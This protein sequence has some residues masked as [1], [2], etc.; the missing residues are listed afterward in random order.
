MLFHL[1]AN[2]QKTISMTAYDPGTA[3]GSAVARA[4]SLVFVKDG[5]VMP[6]FI[7]APVWL[8]G[9]KLWWPLAA[10]VASIGAIVGIVY[11][12]D[13]P[14]VIAV[15]GLIAVHLV[16]AFEAGDLQRAGLEG[17][18]YVTLGTVTGRDVLDC[19]RRFFDLWLAGRAGERGSAGT[20]E[21]ARSSGETQRKSVASRPRVIGDLLGFG[22]KS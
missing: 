2:G 14:P 3:T 10:Y 4:E 17:D 15:L 7:G 5:F 8:V 11:V 19:E 16:V 22:R 20:G 9:E 12:F 6:A 13:L 1:L 18:G 21:P